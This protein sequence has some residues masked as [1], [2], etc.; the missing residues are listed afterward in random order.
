V[1][2]R[3]TGPNQAWHID[4]TIIKFLDGTKAYLHGVIDNF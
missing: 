2:F 3:A 1:G 4:V